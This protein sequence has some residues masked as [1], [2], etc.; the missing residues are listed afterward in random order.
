MV[1]SDIGTGFAQDFTDMLAQ[2]GV[3]HMHTSLHPAA[4]G[5]FEQLV[6]SDKEITAKP[7]SS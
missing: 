6:R 1:T 2:L 7:S 4:N 3:K 5:A